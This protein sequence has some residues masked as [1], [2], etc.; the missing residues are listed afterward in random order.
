MQTSE[1]DQEQ[2]PQLILVLGKSQN[3]LGSVLEGNRKCQNCV[4]ALVSV[5][6][7]HCLLSFSRCEEAVAEGIIRSRVQM[8]GKERYRATCS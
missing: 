3:V 2:G 4:E 7:S 8:P 5:L 6:L 1:V